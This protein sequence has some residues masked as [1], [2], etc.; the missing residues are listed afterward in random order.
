MFSRASERSAFLYNFHLVGEATPTGRASKLFVKNACLLFAKNIASQKANDDIK[1]NEDE[2]EDLEDFHDFKDTKSSAEDI[3]EIHDRSQTSSDLSDLKDLDD[4]IAPS[5]PGGQISRKTEAFQCNLC[6]A[7]FGF[8]FNIKRHFHKA[9]PDETYENLNIKNINFNCYECDGEIEFD[10]FQSLE[11]HFASIHQGQVLNRE[12]VYLGDTNTTAAK[13]QSVKSLPELQTKKSSNDTIQELSEVKAD[14]DGIYRCQACNFSTKYNQNLHAHFRTLKHTKGVKVDQK[15]NQDYDSM[16]NI[17]DNEIVVCTSCNFEG[18]NRKSIA[19]HWT[20]NPECR[21]GEFTKKTVVPPSPM[22]KPASALLGIPRGTRS[23]RSPAVYAPLSST[24]LHNLAPAPI[25]NIPIA[26]RNFLGHPIIKKPTTNKPCTITSSTPIPPCP[27]PMNT[28]ELLSPTSPTSEDKPAASATPSISEIEI[29]AEIKIEVASPTSGELL[30]PASPTSGELLGL[31]SSTSG[32]PL[33]LSG[34]LLSPD[35]STSGEPLSLSG[36]LPCPASPTSGKPLSLSGEL[37]SPALPT[38]GEP[39]SLSTPT[40]VPSS[41][42]G[43]SAPSSGMDKAWPLNENPES[44]VPTRP[45]GQPKPTSAALGKSNTHMNPNVVVSA[46]AGQRA[47]TAQERSILFWS[48]SEER[49]PS[50]SKDF[51]T[52]KDD[53]K[54]R[55]ETAQELSENLEVKTKEAEKEASKQRDQSQSPTSNS[56]TVPTLSTATPTLV[57]IS[58]NFVPI[59]DHLQLFV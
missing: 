56:T 11:V 41:L 59:F 58:H 21:K 45:S 27:S 34:E 5:S 50:V 48:N 39:L 8:K 17:Q 26:P 54:E 53:I 23:P 38:S 33:S 29:K 44:E 7:V 35:S 22:K 42:P 32:E 16:M 15:L 36:E 49:D 31:A 37:L 20:R 4:E 47:K 57:R 46:H 18:K 3:I 40:L 52:E 25:L 55:D 2:N 12:K 10:T 6:N 24:S 1:Q 43:T 19:V 51:E 9:H 14:G 28:G 30:S 13:F